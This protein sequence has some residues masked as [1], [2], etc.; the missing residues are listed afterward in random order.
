MSIEDMVREERRMRH[1]DGGESQRFAERIAKDVKFDVPYL[2]HH[3]RT[4]L[5]LS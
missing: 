5:M 2:T 3:H 4:W 1:Q